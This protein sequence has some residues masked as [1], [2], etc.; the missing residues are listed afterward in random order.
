MQSR[1]PPNFSSSARAA[2]LISFSWRPC[3][4]LD[5]GS[6]IS[7]T[8]ASL[9]TASL[10]ISSLL[11][12]NS[13]PKPESPVTLSSGCARLASRPSPTGS[14]EFAITMGMVLVAPFAANAGGPEL[15]TIRSTLRRTNSAASSGRRSGFC[16][17]NR[18]SKVML[19]PSIHPSLLSSCRKASW[20]AAYRGSPDTFVSFPSEHYSIGFPSFT[21]SSFLAALFFTCSVASSTVEKT[22]LISC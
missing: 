18:Y 13:T 5:P 9:V 11:V 17:A 16:S 15:A 12:F 21:D 7:P 14:A 19:F 8:R 2:A 4:I 10:S 20:G 6:R 22:M 3:D 1:S